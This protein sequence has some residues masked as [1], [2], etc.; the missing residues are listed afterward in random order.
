MNIT[1]SIIT[2][3]YE[4][5]P[6]GRVASIIEDHHNVKVTDTLVEKYI[7][8]AS[9]KRF[10]FDS[11]ALEIR[12]LNKFDNIIE[13]KIEFILEDHTSVFVSNNNFI[14]MKELIGENQEAIDF[15]NKTKE[16]FLNVFTLLNI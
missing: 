12:N 15:M 11:V 9:K 16:N 6:Y 8:F 3:V 1:E 5:L 14:K 2:E 10:T 13:G 7:E 4:S